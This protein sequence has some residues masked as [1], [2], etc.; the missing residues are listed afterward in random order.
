MAKNWTEILSIKLKKLQDNNSGSI[1]QIEVNKLTKE[2]LTTVD[3]YV[4]AKQRNVI[5]NQVDTI[6][7]QIAGLKKDISVMGNNILQEN[8]I[9]EIATELHS[10]ITQ[11]EKSV[12]GILDISD[13]IRK[14]SAKASP[15]KL[16][17][18]LLSHST[19]ILELCNFQDLTGQIIQRIIKR[20]TIIESTVN[21][22]ATELGPHYKL[23]S[24]LTPDS[25]LNGPQKEEDRPSQ[26]DIDN[27][28]ADLPEPKS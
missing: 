26:D 3:Y 19:K 27:L 28:F 23:S 11:T 5:F 21:N 24:R 17:E 10:V 15:P 1:N 7:Q 2:F 6:S 8:F 12:I 4:S 18:E 13:E 16:K 25:L 22:I 20:L 9:P 14:I